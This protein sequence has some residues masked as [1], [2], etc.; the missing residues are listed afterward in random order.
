MSC[1]GM[2]EKVVILLRQR[3][4]ERDFERNN[5]RNSLHRNRLAHNYIT[6]MILP[7]SLINLFVVEDIYIFSGSTKLKPIEG[8]ARSGAMTRGL[9]SPS[10]KAQQR[11]NAASLL[12][13]FGCD[14]QPSPPSSFN[15]SFRILASAICLLKICQKTP[16]MRSNVDKLN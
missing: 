11:A 13:E 6:G 12:P 7:F 15:K 10:R 3:P 9:L 14:L 4:K 8:R 1:S 2:R 5:R 16:S